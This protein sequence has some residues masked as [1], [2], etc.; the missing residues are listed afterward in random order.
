MPEALTETQRMM[1]EALLKGKTP[2]TKVAEEVKCSVAQVKKMS[3][4][5]NKYGSVVAPKFGK[6]GKAIN[7]DL[8]D[9]RCMI[10]LLFD[11]LKAKILYR[12]YVSL[13]RIS[14]ISIE[15]NWPISSQKSSMY[16]YQ[17]LQS[18]ECSNK[19][20]YLIKRCLFNN[21]SP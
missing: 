14:L 19:R 13:L 4:N 5:W 21:I 15:T 18:A 9:E 6:R 12:L 7:C 8:R 3:M 16:M 17:M 20:K 2:H 11:R 1:V 10:F